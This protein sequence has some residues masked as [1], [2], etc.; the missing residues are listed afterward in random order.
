MTTLQETLSTDRSD[1]IAAI[2]QRTLTNPAMVYPFTAAAPFLAG[3]LRALYRP[4]SRLQAVGHVT[5]EIEIAAGQAEIELLEHIG[6]SPFSGGMEAAFAGNPLPHDILYVANPNRVTGA[7]FSVADLQR[8]AEAAPNGA[9]IIDEYYYDYFGITGLPLLDGFP[10]VILLR[11]FGSTGGLRIGDEPGYAIACPQT[12]EWMK[13]A[14]P[15]AG[16]ERLQ[17]RQLI[18]R[19]PDEETQAA[20]LRGVHEESLR[21]AEA[22]TRLGVQCRLS[23]SDFIL[24]RVADPTRV[25]NHL[26]R[27]CVAIDNLDGY[28]AMQH[29]LRYQVSSPLANDRLLQAFQ[30]MP[31]EAYRMKDL[32]CRAITL[33]LAA[34]AAPAAHRMVE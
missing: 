12:V 19:L 7:S 14:A 2:T 6:P 15:T 30:A 17:A 29:Y 3:L 34:Q 8:M 20:R 28:P 21:L 31:P 32:D 11:S 27:S 33:R 24:L 5:P 9:L 18:D 1:L 25:G 22:L 13:E 16:I 4:G 10:N 23:T 26:T